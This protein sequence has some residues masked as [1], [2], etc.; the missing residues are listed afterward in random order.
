L[1]LLTL[2]ACFGGWLSTSMDTCSCVWVD[3]VVW[4]IH[5]TSKEIKESRLISIS[6]ESSFCSGFS[7]FL[8]LL[9]LVDFEVS[10][11]ESECSNDEENEEVDNLEGKISLELKVFP[12]S[13][14]VSLRFWDC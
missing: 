2:V 14:D 8:G 5:L 1:L 3:G 13:F 9:L 10:V 12:F 4:V 11:Q 7:F 6:I